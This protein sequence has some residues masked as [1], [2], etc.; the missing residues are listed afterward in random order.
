MDRLKKLD[1]RLDD[2]K[3]IPECE[4][5]EKCDINDFP[6]ICQAAEIFLPKDLEEIKKRYI[7]S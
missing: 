5:M 3:P 1:H 6:S 2:N 7:K 4:A